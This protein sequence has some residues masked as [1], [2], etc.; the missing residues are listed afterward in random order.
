MTVQMNKR[1]RLLCFGKGNI[2][3]SK[4]KTEKTIDGVAFT[5]WD[6]R[7]AVG[8]VLSEAEDT[9]INNMAQ[10]VIM[11]FDRIDSVQVVIDAL[12]DVKTSLI[13]ATYRS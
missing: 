3:V 1:T 12:E 8:S 13:E 10:D 9:E 7:K 5:K 11:Q 4:L 6:K 2:V